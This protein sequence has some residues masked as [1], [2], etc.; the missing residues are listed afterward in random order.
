MQTAPRHHEE[1]LPIPADPVKAFIQTRLAR[2][3]TTRQI[4]DA[5]EIHLGIAIDRDQVIPF[6]KGEIPL[7]TQTG[8]RQDK[9][10]VQFPADEVK[11][12]IFT[13]MAGGEPPHRMAEAAATAPFSSTLDPGQVFDAREETTS[14]LTEEVEAFIVNCAARY[15]T[16]TRAS[17]ACAV[18]IFSTQTEHVQERATLTGPLQVHPTL[19]GPL[20]ERATLTGPLQEDAT[21]TGQSPDEKAATILTDEIKAF[22][23]RGLARYETPSRVA[24]AVK[25]IFDIEVSRQLVHT[26]NARGA[27]PPAERWCELFDLT[28]KNFLADASALG[29]AQK[30]VRLRMLERFAQH[31]DE[32]GYYTRAAGFLEQAAKECGG[33]YEGRKSSA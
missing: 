17:I 30:M 3:E 6:W 5:V 20:P 10:S 1:A 22:I 32:N 21:L 18:D 26:Y 31:A 23:V 11:E 29:I 28:R 14:S 9:E 12:P 24:A 25:A 33:I 16:T 2:N 4:A 27:K 8:R 7:P 13:R 19:T 15:E